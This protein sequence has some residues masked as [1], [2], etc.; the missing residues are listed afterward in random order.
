MFM[1]GLTDELSKSY[2][3]CYINGKYIGTAQPTLHNLY[4]YSPANSTSPILIKPS[5]YYIAY[6]GTAHPTVYSLCG[7][8]LVN[9]T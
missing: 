1:D 4:E 6:I 9:I 5:Q 8:S 7:Y 2:A 3:G